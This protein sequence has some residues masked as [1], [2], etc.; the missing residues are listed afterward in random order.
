MSL[1][2]FGLPQWLSD[3]ESAGNAG[4][5]GDA[6]LIPGSERSP[7]GG[8]GNPLHYS[9]LENSMDR[10]AWW[11]TIHAITESD[12]TAVTKH[13][14]TLCFMHTYHVPCTHAVFH[15]HM[16]CFRHSVKH[17]TCIYPLNFPSILMGKILFSASIITH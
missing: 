3:E 15:A 2:C 12:M 4:A 17:L 16:P 7:G 1:L 13:T 11:A 8:Y 9:C 10:G 6:H 14:H 5:A